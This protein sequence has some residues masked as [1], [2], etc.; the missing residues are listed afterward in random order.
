MRKISKIIGLVLLAFMALLIVTALIF[1][2]FAKANSR[3]WGDS[4]QI[5]KSD[6]KNP[7]KAL[8][9]YQPSRSGATS[10]IAGKIAQGIND[11]G[12]EVTINY[13]GKHTSIDISQ[14]SIVAFGSPVYF[15][16]T[17]SALTN[18]VKSLKDFSNKKILLFTVGQLKDEELD[19][20]EQLLGGAKAAEKVKFI[21][22]LKIGT[23]D[24][25]AAYMIAKRFAGE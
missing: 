13:P 1:A 7:K 4:A 23:K 20:M 3:D 16:Q 24:E 14:Y 19:K 6:R 12:Y 15:A 17:S 18:Y 2:W 10:A 5:L 25:T 8:V 21:I 11:A 9:I 22:K